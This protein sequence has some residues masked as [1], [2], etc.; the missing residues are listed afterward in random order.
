MRRVSVPAE[1]ISAH[2]RL[3][4]RTVR[5]ILRAKERL[6]GEA[7][8]PRGLRGARMVRVSM[9]VRIFEV[10]EGVVRLDKE[11]RRVLEDGLRDALRL[12]VTQRWMNEVVYPRLG[13]AQGQGQG[14]DFPHGQVE[15][16]G[17]NQGQSQATNSGGS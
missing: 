4:G 7:S 6:V 3:A 5:D 11:E 16:Q 8:H 14:N 10:G 12:G 13:P 9:F 15:D 2:P 1:I 17:Q